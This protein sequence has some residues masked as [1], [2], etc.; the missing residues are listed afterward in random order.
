M[1]GSGQRISQRVAC[2]LPGWYSGTRISA[3]RLRRD[4]ATYTGASYPGTS[5]L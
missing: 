2:S 4:Q 1:A 5:R 3:E